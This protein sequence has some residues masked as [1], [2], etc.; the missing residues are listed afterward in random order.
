MI[1]AS[2]NDLSLEARCFEFLLL[3]FL[4]G[5]GRHQF[6]QF[7]ACDILMKLFLHVYFDKS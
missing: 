3:F 1:R 4:G 2:V 5:G 6:L 7:I